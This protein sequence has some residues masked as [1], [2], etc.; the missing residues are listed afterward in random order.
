M[1]GLEDHCFRFTSDEL[2]NGLPAQLV[3][4]RNTKKESVSYLVF[5]CLDKILVA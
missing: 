4:V 2:F 3:D 1:Q 5:R